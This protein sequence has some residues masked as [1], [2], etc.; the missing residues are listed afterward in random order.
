M[1]SNESKSVLN[2]SKSELNES[3]SWLNESKSWLN[4]SKSWLNECKSLLNDSKSWLNEYKSHLKHDN[5]NTTR[6]EGETNPYLIGE[7]L[8]EGEARWTRSLAFLDHDTDAEA[9]VGFSEGD[10]ALPVGIDCERSNRYISSLHG[11]HEQDIIFRTV[12]ELKFAS[13]F[14]NNWALV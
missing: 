1:N 6:C 5:A 2:E 7:G 12:V 11:K 3:E 14:G 4:E 9:H 13:P 8:E 10:H